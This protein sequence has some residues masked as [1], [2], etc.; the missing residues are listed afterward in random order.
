MINY[1]ITVTYDQAKEL[2]KASAP[3]LEDCEVEAESRAEVVALLEQEIEDRIGNMRAQK[4]EPPRPIDE[5]ELDGELSIH[6]SQSLHRDL[7]YRAKLEKVELEEYLTELLTRSLTLRRSSGGPPNKGQGKRGRQREG[8]GQRYHDIMENR[9]DFIEY[10][11]GLDKGDS[12]G[13][14]GG[15][16]RGQR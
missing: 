2:F 13:G 15:G 3:E 9:A 7:L 1:R 10:V 6:V 4:I 8:Q 5:Q 12:R 16:R 11:R 14:K